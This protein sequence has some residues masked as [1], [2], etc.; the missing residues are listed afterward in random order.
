MNLTYI[1]IALTILASLFIRDKRIII[2]LA[3]LSSITIFVKGMIIG[4]IMLF[5]LAGV[6]FYMIKIKR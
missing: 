1:L 6:V 3:I 5:V 2:I 4:I